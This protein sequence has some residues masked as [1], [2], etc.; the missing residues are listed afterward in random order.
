MWSLSTY[1][2]E[3]DWTG[4]MPMKKGGEKGNVYKLR[5]GNEMAKGSR[6]R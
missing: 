5:K 4:L 2:N 3:E 6:N 1:N